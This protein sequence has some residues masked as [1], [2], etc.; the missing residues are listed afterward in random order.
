MSENLISAAEKIRKLFFFCLP[1][2]VLFGPITKSKQGYIENTLSLPQPPKN[3]YYCLSDL[4]TKPK[5]KNLLFGLLWLLGR[6]R[7]IF[8]LVTN[9]CI[10]CHDYAGWAGYEFLFNIFLSRIC[11]L[12]RESTSFFS[13]GNLNTFLFK[14]SYLGSD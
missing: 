7:H 5:K 12:A 10:C 4:T 11:D 6:T 1:V 14:F 13:L 2:N 9:I 8:V 3:M